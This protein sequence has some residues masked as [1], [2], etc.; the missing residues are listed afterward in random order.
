VQV[1]AFSAC[2]LALEGE[3][4]GAAEARPGSIVAGL[5]ARVGRMQAE[6]AELQAR[7]EQ[8]RAE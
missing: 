5:Q 2:P 8:E 3:G 6:L 1:I 7:V 4:A